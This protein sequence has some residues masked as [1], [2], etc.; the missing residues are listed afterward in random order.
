MVAFYSTLAEPGDG[1]MH[2]W[3]IDQAREDANDQ[4]ANP[5]QWTDCPRCLG[6]GIVPA[7]L[8]PTNTL[9]VRV[10][11]PV[12]FGDKKIKKNA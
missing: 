12:C 7:A 6:V 4:A 3:R 2:S 8:R 1:L 10:L 5:D 9:S 11:C